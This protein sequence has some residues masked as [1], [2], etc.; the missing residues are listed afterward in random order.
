[1]KYHGKIGIF[2]VNLLSDICEVAD[3]IY[4]RNIL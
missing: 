4:P 1:M 2:E 3:G